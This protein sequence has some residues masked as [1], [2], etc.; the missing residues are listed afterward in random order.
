MWRIEASFFDENP[1]IA[2]NA[3]VFDSNQASPFYWYYQ[4]KAQIA[5]V[6]RKSK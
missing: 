4:L 6:V 1:T 2:L 5:P 3:H